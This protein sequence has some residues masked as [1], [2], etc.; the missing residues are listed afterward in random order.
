MPKKKDDKL[1]TSAFDRIANRGTLRSQ[2]TVHFWFEWID[3]N[4]AR[5]K[6]YTK[7]ENDQAWDYAKEQADIFVK[8]IRKCKKEG[9]SLE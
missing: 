3:F 2:M 5:N 4:V 9:R 6:K 1:D 8:M 7:D